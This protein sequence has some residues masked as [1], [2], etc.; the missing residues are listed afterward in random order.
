MAIGS[1]AED[2][3]EVDG[4]D[5]AAGDD[6]GEGGAGADAGELIFVTDEEDVGFF[7]EGPQEF[8]QEGNIDHRRL[9]GDEEIAVEG[10]I[11]V[12]SVASWRLVFQEAVDGFG[13][14][15][16]GIG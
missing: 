9:I 2:F 11:G 5:G 4:R 8:V 1:L 10:V 13:I 6:I 12:A 7:R 15:A 16:G 3:F 14:V